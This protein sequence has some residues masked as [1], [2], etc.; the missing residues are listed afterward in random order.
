MTHASLENRTAIVTGAARG[1]GAAIAERLAAAGATVLIADILEEEGERTARRLRETGFQ[2]RYVYL[3]VTQDLSWEAA[4]F[5]A[6][7]ATERFDIL[8][9]NA[10]VELTAPILETD[11]AALRRL[12]DV[13][14]G[15]VC[16]GMKHAFDAMRPLGAAG[17]G[18]VIVN[19]SS[20]AAKCATP[21]SGP[22]AASKAAVEKLSTVGAT[23]AA[24]LGYGVRVNCVFPGFVQTDLS[25]ASARTAIRMGLFPDQA[26]FDAFVLNSTPLGRFGEARDVAEAVAFLCSDEAGFIT[27]AGLSVAGGMAA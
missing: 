7:T 19:V 22:Y 6:I 1:I 20:I 17:E 12:F 5:D 25:A 13:N 14:V 23:E 18:G 4:I 24:R 15:G 3:D 11:A 2:A 21:L 9:N 10:G 16:L 8:V 26:S 27:G